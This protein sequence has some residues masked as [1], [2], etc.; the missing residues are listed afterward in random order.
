MN[1]LITGG[2]GFIGSNFVD[3]VLNE[4][5]TSINKVVNLDAL[6]YAGSLKNTEEFEKDEKYVFEKVNICNFNEVLRVCNEHDITH[7]V[8]LAAESH[9][10][11]SIL[12]ARAFIDTN[13]VGTYNLLQVAHQNN[14][15]FHH[16]STDEVYG[17]LDEIGKFTED[18]SYDPRNP[19]SASKA[20]SDFLVMAYYHTYGL[21]M[22]I[23]NCSNNYGP[24]QHEEKF[25]PKIISCIMNG[26]KIPLYG[27]GTNI[28][29]WIYV[30][31][32]CEG[33]WDVL[34]TGRIGETYCIGAN[35]EKRNIEIIRDICSV[36]QV[37]P[38]ESIEFVKD[39]LGH[40]YRYAIDSTKIMESLGWNP[41]TS[42]E[43]GIKETIR[44]YN[45]KN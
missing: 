27:T 39:R 1:L 10:D 37:S 8:H 25:I 15:R 21:Q 14:L 26:D 43:S 9:V 17:E 12:D 38:E 41:E 3:L 5:R 23:S 33:L 4:K 29:D 24:R 31:D 35:C 7:I 45:E 30:K 6:T 28:R 18:T 32:H 11:N 13:V 42:F 16:V 20:A 34:Q 22:T 44:W 36:M 40:D 2:C 19:Y